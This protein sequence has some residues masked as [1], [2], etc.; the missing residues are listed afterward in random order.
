MHQNFCDMNNLDP[1]NLSQRIIRQIKSYSQV[2]KCCKYKLQ[3][4]FYKKVYGM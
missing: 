4:K 3:A 2:E 1:W